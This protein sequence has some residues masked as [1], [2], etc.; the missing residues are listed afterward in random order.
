MIKNT[1]NSINIFNVQYNCEKR[2][3]CDIKYKLLCREPPSADK[4]EKSHYSRFELLLSWRRTL[5]RKTR[6]KTYYTVL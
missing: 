5:T 1:V 3:S 6:I 2:C 4:G